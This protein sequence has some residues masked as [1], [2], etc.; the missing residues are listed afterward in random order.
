MSTHGF[1]LGT[2]DLASGQPHEDGYTLSVLGAGASFGQSQAVVRQIVSMLADGDLV[3]YDR[4]GNRVAEFDVL[5]EGADGVALQA[6]EVALRRELY[7]PNAVTW[8]P[9]AD[10]SA[11]TVYEVVTSEMAPKFDDIDELRTRRVF[12]VTLTCAPFA[13]P[14]AAI[15]VPALAPPAVSPTTATINDA[16]STTG[17]SA[18]AQTMVDGLVTDIVPVSVTDLGADGVSVSAE[19]IFLQFTYTPPAPIALTG[20]P[21]VTVELSGSVPDLFSIVHPTGAASGATPTLVRALTNGHTQYVLPVDPA[22]PLVRVDV[23]WSKTYYPTPTVVTFNA[24]DISRTDT[25]PQIS[26]RQ[27]SRIVSVAGTERTPASL[28]ISAPNGTDDLAMT[29]VHTSPEDGSGYAPP[30]RRWRVSGGTVTAD[31]STM[32]GGREPIVLANPFIAEVPNLAVPEGGYLLAARTRI[33]SGT[34]ATINWATDTQIDGATEGY[35]TDAATFDFPSTGNWFFTPIA[36]LTLPSVR[37]MSGKVRILLS[38]TN[39]ELDEAWLFRVDDGCAL[40]VVHYGA[41]PRLWLDSPDV[42]SQVPRIWIGDNTSRADAS[43]PGANL[44][45]HGNHTF[46]PDAMA[47]FVGTSG[48]ENP[49]AA[50]TYYPRWHSNAAS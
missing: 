34:S 37:S 43:H 27:I 26:T 16:T 22:R 38:S 20:T 4:A 24:F 33:A 13:R 6:G 9:P 32:S 8:T 47:V 45:A 28:A 11:P 12:H 44:Y 3:S 25:L 21:Y 50:L 46:T 15:T 31:A 39:A 29:I 35:V 1:D 7:R 42:S 17:W 10:F 19:C 30:L 36:V 18:R 23:F 41:K 48:T 49:E 2:L 14:P 5:I 40:T